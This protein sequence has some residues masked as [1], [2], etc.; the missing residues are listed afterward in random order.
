MS[1]AQ[2]KTSFQLDDELDYGMKITAKDTNTFKLRSVACKFCRN[3][4]HEKN[5][6]ARGKRTANIKYFSLPFWPAH[7]QEHH[8]SQ[9]KSVCNEYKGLYRTDKAAFFAYNL[10][11]GSTLHVHFEEVWRLKFTI[12][13]EIDKRNHWRC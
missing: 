13:K 1:G 4:G 7:Y 10:D 9:H 6:G 8:A 3:V 2:R 11:V 12:K 5:F